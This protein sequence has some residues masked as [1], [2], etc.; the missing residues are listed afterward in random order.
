[1]RNSGTWG[2]R[3]MIF[4]WSVFALGPLYW[5]ITTAFKSQIDIYSGPRFGPFIDY[6]PTMQAWTTLFG[7]ARSSFLASLGNSVVFATMSAALAVL[8]GA[9]GAYGLSRHRYKYGPYKNDDLSLLIVSQ[10]IMPPIVSVLA[11]YVIYVGLRLLDT[12]SGMI[13]AY[14]AANLP[15]ALYLLRSF[16]D[17]IPVE[18]EHAAAL[19]GYPRRH[20]LAKV[21]FP[22]AAPGLAAA[23][24]LSFF[25]AWNDFLFALVLTFNKAQTLPLFI[26]SLTA[27]SQPLWWLISAAALIALIPPALVTL[28]LDRYMSRQV[29]AGGLR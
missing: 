22:L 11:L 29:L 5:T 17:A 8:F 10:R 24:M 7:S 19:D 23:F 25:F 4:V 28:L 21:V 9:L 13:L 6:Q 14:T 3:A 1:M 12:T 15:L 2:R 27:Q 16:F 26:T 20:R 18:M